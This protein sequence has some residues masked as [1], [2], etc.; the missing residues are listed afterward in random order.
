MKKY[1][2]KAGTFA[3]IL[4]ASTLTL[5]SCG[6]DDEGESNK[7]GSEQPDEPVTPEK[8]S[9]GEALDPLQQK[10]RME[11]IAKDVLAMMPAS[12]FREYTDLAHHI[13]REYNEDYNWESVNKWARQ[14]WDDALKSIGKTSDKDEWSEYIYTEYKCLL[15]ASNFVGHFTAGNGKWTK[16][17]GK[18]NDLQFSFNAQ[19]GEKCVLKIETSGKVTKVYA[20]DWDDWKDYEDNY[21]PETGNYSYTEYYDRYK[22]TIGVPEKVV[23][24]LTQ[25]GKQLVKTSVDIALSGVSN[26]TLD[27]S[28]AK[29]SVKA[30]VELSNGYTISSSQVNYAGNSKVSV[31]LASVK[32]NGTALVTVAMSGDVTG[33]PS[34][35][36]DAFSKDNFRLDDYN[37]TNSTLKNAFVK[38]DVL[39]KM[40][41]QGVISDIHK[42]SDYLDLA[43][44]NYNNESNFKSYVKKANELA[45]FNLFYDNTSTKQ[46]SVV[47]DPFLDYEYDGEQE[48]EYEPVLVFFD[49]SSNSAFGNFFNEKDFKS[50]IKMYENMLGDYENLIKK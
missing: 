26:E 46:A 8:P 27:V 30:D 40:Q 36:L 33:L 45:D 7:P 25:G 48:W 11:Q 24:T 39:G 49:G 21:D 37:T 5:T 28:K 32:K 50:L 23:V 4:L 13:E 35:N 6:D 10:Q 47:L 42:Y 43:D 12:D 19:T 17:V 31:A 20:G 14:C 18:F 15:L 3:T 29:L 41:L 9:T 22:C 16:D 38:V 1:L 2:F 44:R 34:C